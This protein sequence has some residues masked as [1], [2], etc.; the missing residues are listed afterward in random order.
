MKLEHMH[1]V[2]R[3]ATLAAIVTGYLGGTV[4]AISPV[5]WVLFV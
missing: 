3:F 5:L 2:F 1:L 4:P